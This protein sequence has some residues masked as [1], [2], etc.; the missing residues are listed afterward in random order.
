MFLE[1][2]SLWGERDVH[3]GDFCKPL[4]QQH[5]CLMEWQS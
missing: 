2:Q 3:G 4:I 1:A 5:T